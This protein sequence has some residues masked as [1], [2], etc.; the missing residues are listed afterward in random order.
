MLRLPCE[1]GNSPMQ[2][3][4]FLS[5]LALAAT[6]VS[7]QSLTTTFAGGNGQSGNM[8]DVVGV[9]NVT[10][11]GFDL[12]LAAGTFNLEVYT[13]PAGTS[14]LGN[15]ANPAAWTLVGSAANVTSVGANLPTPLPITL[16]VPVAAG[17]TQGFYVT[18]TNGTMN[19]TNGTTFGNVYAQ[20]SFI[21]VLEGDGIAYPFA[22]TYTPRIVNAN[23]YY[24]PAG[25]GTFGTNTV[26]GVGCGGSAA[27]DG[28]FYQLFDGTT[29]TFDLSN[30]S[31]TLVWSGSG[32]IV[33][34]G[35]SPVVAPTGS[36]LTLGDDV[37]VPVNLPFALPCSAGPISAISLCSN[38]WLQ[39]GSTTNNA[40]GESVTGLLTG[41]PRLCFL[42]DDLNP[43]VGGT[44]NAEVDG[45]GVFHIT[46]TNVPEY[47][48]T[49]ANTVQVSLS[50]SGNIE[51]K[52]GA[53]AVLD[54]LVG[55]STGV[56]AT[57]PGNS[58]LSTALPIIVNTGAFVPTLT[59]AGAT[60]PVLGTS[61]NLN[62][63]AVPATGVLGADI[64]GV[65]DPNVPDLFFL[66]LPGCGLRAS[67]DLINV[68]PVTGSTHSYG[69]SLPNNPSF[70]GLD[71]FTTGAV[72]QVPPVNAFGAITS[73]GVKGHLGDI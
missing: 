46:F 4:R 72:F 47:G 69:L 36:P 25:G 19:Y 14:I 55:L 60:R 24:A 12:N 56:N 32:Y 45:A 11:T 6:A 70:I 28:S 64:F 48:T 23:V 33:I 22:G 10:I 27:G 71:L 39:F 7:A 40:L 61:W 5:I 49:N 51:L 54:S 17:Q 1:P 9:Q 58:D 37:T 63:S 62:L 44:V 26:L 30:T 59:L 31:M 2:T 35:A 50:P 73:N 53:I 8:F 68:W 65:T 15:E 34:P 16:S 18:T 21:Q 13:L 57:D 52:Y 67:P 41:G 20:D 38:G 3:M 42:W 66:G 43:S 29:S